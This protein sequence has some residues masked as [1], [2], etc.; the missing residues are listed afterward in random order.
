MKA[1][2]HYINEALI[3]KDT[4]IIYYNKELLEN[5][6]SF[7][8]IN[9]YYNDYEKIKQSIIDWIND[10]NVN[11]IEFYYLPNKN[12]LNAT[13]NLEKIQDKIIINPSIN[14][15]IEKDG[16]NSNCKKYY[17]FQPGILFEGN[18]KYFRLKLNN[19]SWCI[20]EKK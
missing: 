3:K 8:S 19:D 1:L 5:I 6:L 10:Y 9:D 12:M 7:F 4:K 20:V 2:N 15:L 13:L 11:D 17:R 14:K 18:E 16:F